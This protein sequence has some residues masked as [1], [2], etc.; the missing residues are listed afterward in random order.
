MSK[1]TALTVIEDS[2]KYM[3]SQ[4]DID[5]MMHDIGDIISRHIFGVVTIAGGCAGVFKVLEPGAEETMN[6]VQSIEGVILAAHKVNVRWGHDYGSRQQG[7][8]PVC[9]SLDGVTGVVLETGET[10]QCESC[11]YN[12]YGENGQR[13][14]C[15]NKHQLYILREGDLLPVLFSIPPTS[16]KAY[17][18]YR[19][20][21]SV[22]MRCP[23]SALVTRITLKNEV[24]KNG[25]EY[26]TAVFTAVAKLPLEE[27]KRMEAFAAQIVDAAKRAGASADEIVNEGMQAPPASGSFVQVDDE[28]LPFEG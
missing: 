2:S 9:R 20:R 23:M 11:P 22:T 19:I 7:E 8:Q 17:N 3:P 14:A 10:V 25:N 12:Q 16:L 6:G 27:G 4:Q 18:N 26:S 1:S 13:K 28:D 5:T 21:A 15:S 24:N